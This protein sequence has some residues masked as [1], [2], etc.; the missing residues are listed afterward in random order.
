MEWEKSNPANTDN[1]F[2]CT[3][4]HIC[5]YYVAITLYKKFMH[6]AKNVSTYLINSVVHTLG[7]DSHLN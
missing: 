5:A 4:F 6:G 1:L 7:V 2:I 3:I